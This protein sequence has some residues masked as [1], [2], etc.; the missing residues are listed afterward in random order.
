M[1][2]TTSKVLHAALNDGLPVTIGGSVSATV[3][4]GLHISDIAVIVSA[5][6]AVMGVLL[7]F[8]V[9]MRRIHLLEAEMV[10]ARV[11]SDKNAATAAA[12][13][14]VASAASVANRT[15]AGQ[16]SNL[17]SKIDP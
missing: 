16:V 17:Q 1:S 6:A 8:Y 14:V 4:W 11:K 12:A 15:L 5:L 13:G 2:P 10:K 3:F 7:Q 9:A